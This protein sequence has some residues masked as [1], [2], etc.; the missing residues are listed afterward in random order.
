M[1]PDLG[2][3]A[4]PVLSSY[5]VSLILLFAVI[6][7]SIWKARRIRARLEQVESRRDRTT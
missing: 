4:V 3:Y 5:G 6:A 1:M 2:T 7:A